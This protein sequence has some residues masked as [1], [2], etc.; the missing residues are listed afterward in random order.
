[1]IDACN[2]LVKK[3]PYQL[4]GLFGMALM[5][6]PIILADNLK[7][8]GNAVPILGRALAPMFRSEWF[9]AAFTAIELIGVTI[10]FFSIYMANRSSPR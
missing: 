5:G 9:P 3:Y 6:V 1:M 2:R 4:L 7:T 10:I 8:L